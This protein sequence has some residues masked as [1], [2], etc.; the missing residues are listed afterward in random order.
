MA[1]KYRNRMFR[2]K[3]WIIKDPIPYIK[4]TGSLY[5]PTV[6]KILRKPK[7]LFLFIHV[8]F[9]IEFK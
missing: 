8:K 4:D 9:S 2:I 5:L 3:I 6:I 7:K 1:T